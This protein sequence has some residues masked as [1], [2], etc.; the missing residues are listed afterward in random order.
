MSYNCVIEMEQITR[1]PYMISAL[2]YG[3]SK[4]IYSCGIMFYILHSTSICIC[5]VLHL[6]YVLHSAV[7]CNRGSITQMCVPQN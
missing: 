2:A 6:F 4:F 7:V 1:Y 5:N 3:L